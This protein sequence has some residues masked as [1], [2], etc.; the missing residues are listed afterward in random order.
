MAPQ[1]VAL[2]SENLTAA[3]APMGAE[4]QYLR[5]TAGADLLCHG[6][7]AH[8]SGRAPV[9]FPIVGRAV[10]DRVRSG[11]VTAEM[12]QHGFARRMT[13]E[14]ED[15]SE[16]HCVH[17]LHASDKTRAVYPFEFSLRVTHALEGAQLQ[18]SAEVTNE[19][20]GAMP[21]GFGFHPSFR[22]PLGPTPTQH[23][24][25]LASA[26]NP[27]RRPLRPDGLL[28]R[29]PVPGPFAEGELTIT[30]NLFDDGALVF[31]GGADALTY[32]SANG[33]SLEFSFENLPDLALWRPVGAPFLCIEPW[34]G[35][36]SL[37]GDGPDIADRPGSLT[38]AA[39]EAVTYGYRVL[40][41]P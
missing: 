36:A 38:L 18:V 39:G 28:E 17:V 5:T 8:W 13:F 19:G 33:P 11:G 12:K 40:Y 20:A 29:D 37:V 23:S 35:T 16:A 32:G 15:T 21:F 3:F 34:Q 9:L 7:A 30:D 26:T 22:W 6:D 4:M 10:D 1:L 24:V 2:R 14:V 41:R 27:L 31:P 25:R